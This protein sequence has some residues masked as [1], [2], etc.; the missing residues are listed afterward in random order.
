M[1]VIMYGSGQRC[2]VLLNLIK[3][4]SITVAGIVDSNPKRWGVSLDDIKIES[5]KLLLN[6]KENYVC[7]TFFGENDYEPIWDELTDKYGVAKERILSFHQLLIKIYAESY[8]VPKLPNGMGV[9]RK[10]LF[11]GAWEFGVGG[12]EAWL[13]DTMEALESIPDTF[14]ITKKGQISKNLFD[15]GLLIDYFAPNS[16]G[17][18]L[19][20]VEESMQILM[21]NL[22]CTVVFSRVDELMLASF[23]LKKAYP[24]CIKL[25]SVVHGACDGLVR[26]IFAYDEEIERYLCVSNAACKAMNNL[27]VA[28][29][30]LEVITAPF[31]LDKHE[32]KKYSLNS[33]EPI[34]IGYAGRLE[35]FHKRSDLLIEL[36]KE[37]EKKNVNYDFEI[38]GEGSFAP[39]IKTFLEESKLMHS[40]SYIGAITR[41]EIFDFWRSKDI[42]IN[43]SDSEGRPVSNIE[44]MLCGTVP[45]VTATSGILDD[46]QNEVTGFTVDIGDVSKMAEIIAYLD[47]NRAEIEKV[48]MTAQKCM[49]K[50]TDVQ[51][52]VK[53]WEE[54]LS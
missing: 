3:K 19:E 45:V 22:P 44:A 36:V 13:S 14:I 23:L 33:A 47:K 54:V 29:G 15:K 7:V 21:H 20:F 6:N 37:L 2:S 51:S 50:K 4:S 24:D 31:K 53:R 43:V 8:S 26:D 40:V 46:V 41:E 38:V 52:Y 42:S 30:K 1:Q 17:F 28:E 35:T 32:N 49:E 34:K 10:N 27:G 25:V 39:N 48:G 16:S 12:V 5:P 18:S 11:D 9:K